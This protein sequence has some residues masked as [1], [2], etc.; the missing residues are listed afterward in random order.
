MQDNALCHK[1]VNLFE[2]EWIVQMNQTE[3]QQ[4]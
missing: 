4:K 3:I 2:D 1:V